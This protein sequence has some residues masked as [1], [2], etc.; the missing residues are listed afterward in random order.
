MSPQNSYV[1]ARGPQC[2]YTLRWGLQEAVM[3]VF[4]K[5]DPNLIGLWPYNKGREK[6][7]SLNTVSF[8]EGPGQELSGTRPVSTLILDFP[9]SRTKRNT[10][11]F[12][13]TQSVVFC[14]SCMSWIIQYLCKKKKKVLCPH[15][16]STCN[17]PIAIDVLKYSI[18]FT[19]VTEI[20]T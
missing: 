6:I 12:L 11:Y 13:V 5:Q 4:L 18:H 19:V 1:E 16:E 20:G 9:A 14:Y 3:V 10:F 8:R 15:V 17:F 2:D 7:C